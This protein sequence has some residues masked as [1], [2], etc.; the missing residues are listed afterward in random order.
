[1]PTTTDLESVLGE[2]GID[3]RI[4]LDADTVI[5][6]IDCLEKRHLPGGRIQ[7]LLAISII[8]EKGVPETKLVNVIGGSTAVKKGKRQPGDRDKLLDTDTLPMR[9]SSVFDSEATARSHIEMALRHLLLSCGFLETSAPEGVDRCFKKMGRVFFANVALRCTDGSTGDK[10]KV[11]LD[12]FDKHG[13]EYD[14]ALV[15][16]AFQESIGVSLRDQELWIIR[17]EELLSKKSIG[18]YGVDNQNPNRIYP[19]TIYPQ[20]TALKKYFMNTFPQ[21]KVVRSRYVGFERSNQNRGCR[22]D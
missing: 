6:Q 19:F 3:V 11:L 20:E 9:E 14:Y 4:P 5:H 17:N 8:N 18:I 22:R 15:M 16:S 21:W 10:I 1:M 7:L 2:K 12:L 13:S